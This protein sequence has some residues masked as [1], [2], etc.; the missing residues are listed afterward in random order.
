MIYNSKNI[1]VLKGL[2]GI[3]KRPEMYIGNTKDSTGL[4]KLLY[5]L[6]DNS[7]D[8]YNMNCCD[9]IKIFLKK[10]NYITIEDNGRGIPIDKYKHTR[11]TTAEIILTTLHSGGKFDLQVYK[12]SS[13]LHG[14]GLSAVNALSKKL[15]LFI[16]KKYIRCQ[17]LYINGKLK[18][19]LFSLHTSEKTK[20]QITFYPNSKFIQTTN[21][22][23]YNIKQHIEEILFLNETLYID[24]FFNKKKQKLITT[25]NRGLP[26]Y[27]NYLSTTN[28]IP[29]GYMLHKKKITDDNEINVCLQWTFSEKDII[30]CYTNNIL[31]KEGGS[32]LIGL[33]NGIVNSIQKFLQE[34]KYKTYF[35]K[36]I[37]WNVIKKGLI[38]I[39]SIKML[40]PKFSSQTKEKLIS[41]EIKKQI[42][43]FFYIEIKD[44]LKKNSEI[45]EIILTNIKNSINIET[46]KKLN[47]KH[48]YQNI[49]PSKFAECQKGNYKELFIVE[50]DS[51]GGSAK[52]ARNR[53]YQA[54]LSIQGKILNTLKAQENQIKQ[55][56]EIQEILNVLNYNIYKQKKKDSLPQTNNYNKIIIMTDAD[57]DGAHICG[58][59]INFFYQTVPEIIKKELLYV[60]QPPLYRLK[61][62]NKIYYINNKSILNKIILKQILYEF[63]LEKNNKIEII[64]DIIN[65]YIEI[66]Y[67]LKQR[68]AQFGKI[69]LKHQLNEI[70]KKFNITSIKNTNFYLQECYKFF[71]KNFIQQKLNLFNVFKPLITS[72]MFIDLNS[73]KLPTKNK[74]YFKTIEFFTKIIL[75]KKRLIKLKRFKGLGEMNPKQLWN[76]TMNPKT[77]CLKKITIKNEQTSTSVLNI[78]FGINSIDRKFYILNNPMINLYKN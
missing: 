62:N 18:K 20:T 72:L 44:F 9:T 60:A 59:L 28:N 45:Q 41:Q 17:Q 54:I 48:I 1:K 33:K 4:H 3:K 10:N 21:F 30:L 35:L 13:G 68:Y 32:H 76:T 16:E 2:S 7:L 39:L 75:K 29:I 63:S 78:L 38:L 14:I 8:E 47:K 24:L 6:I 12:F 11:K 67:I 66:K 23:L 65:Q 46:K 5:E 74:S 50:G 19:T 71:L 15:Q 36:K 58:L 43:N 52:Q 55:N 31:Q 22:S 51:A 53:R 70:E 56:K 77:R 25:N 49:R 73:L 42:E 37:N 26:N 61:S 27:I 57:I 40:N 69:L 64:T 34:K